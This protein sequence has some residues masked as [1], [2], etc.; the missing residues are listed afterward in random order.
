[1]IMAID[2][3][4]LNRVL[5]SVSEKGLTELEIQRRYY[6]KLDKELKGKDRI[7][8]MKILDKIDELELDEDFVEVL[9]S[10]FKEK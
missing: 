8:L 10:K 6:A 7:H 3:N 1:M 2:T 5:D 4:Y 9:T